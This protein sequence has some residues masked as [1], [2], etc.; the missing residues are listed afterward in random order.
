[1]NVNLKVLGVGALFFLGGAAVTAQK[2][3]TVIKTKDIEEVT[4]VV[5]YGKQTKESLTGSV[6]QVKSDVLKQVASANV[7]QGLTGKVAGVQIT[8]N[9]GLPGTEPTV[10]FR[11]IGSINGSSAPLYVVDGVPFNGD[12][13]AINNADIE[14]MSFLKDAS[15]AA[16]YGNRGANGVIIITTKKGRKG[17]TRYNLDVKSGIAMRGIPEYD[18]ITS[19]KEYYEAYHRMLKN[20]YI[21][22]GEAVD[23]AHTSASNELVSLNNTG[24]GYNVTNVAGD[25]IIGADGKF[26]PNASILYQESWADRLFKKGFYTNTYF[27]AAGGTDNT[28]FFYSLGYE[29][30]D[31]YMINSKFEKIT[32]RTKVDSKI[33]EKIKVGANLAYSNIL[34]NAPDGFNGSTSY[35]NPFQWSRSIAPIY[36]VYAYTASGAPVYLPNGERAYDDGTGIYNGGMVRPYG[37]LQNPLATAI[38]DVK[39]NVTNQVFAGGYATLNLFRGLDFTYNVTGE[40]SNLRQHSMDTMLYGDAVGVGGRLYNYNTNIASLTQQQILTYERKFGGL[41]VQAMVGHETM[42]RNIDYISVNFQ[43]GILTSSLASNHYLTLNGAQGRISPYAT[44]GFFGRLNFDYDGKYFI[45]ANARRDGSSRF[46]KDN[47]WGNFFGLGAAWVVSKENFLKNSTWLNNLK[48]KASYGEQGNDNLGITYEYYYY[49]FPYV[50]QFEV[51]Q[52]TNAAETTISLSQTYKGNKNITWEKNANLNAGLELGLFN[53]R[54]TL[55]AEYFSRKSTD[56]LFLKPLPLSQG[57]E[58]M[59]ENIGDMVNRGVEVT[60]NVA[61]VRTSDFEFNINANATYLKNEILRLSEPEILNGSYVLKPGNS[62]YTWRLREFAGVN[63][64]N[65]AALFTVVNATTGEKTL[66]ETYS[67]ATLLDTGK[68]AVPKYYGGFGADAKYKNFDFAISFAYQFGGWGQDTMWLNRFSGDAGANFHKDYANTWTK[69]NTTA[70]LPVLLPGNSK[71]YYGSSTMAL[72]KSDYI[73]LQNVSFGY[74]FDRDMMGNLGIDSL[75]VY[76]V[77]DNVAVWSKRKG[78]DPRMSVRGISSSSYSPIRTISLGFNVG[79]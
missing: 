38:H 42:N 24:L 32:A 19:P 62:M 77:A 22:A 18:I 10:R 29:S 28:S 52:T 35:S 60:A 70:S 45:N 79:F 74:T 3:D 73:S 25:Q 75:R 40:F 43:R 54:L 39:K 46:H 71:Q 9:N 8:T 7:V 31:T 17:K 16:L 61:V 64:T 33:G 4:V 13:A 53:N 36:P 5:A 66:T 6:A 65:G 68:S 14:S 27:S 37:S 15:A 21:N 47:R 41:G 51:V 59:P 57:F 69:S 11:G 26:N 50:D 67:E 58:S 30:N 72:I 12:I 34:Q 23:V 48:L 63:P 55:D 56:M 78:Y 20:G 49:N 76:A 44:E 2:K 1:M